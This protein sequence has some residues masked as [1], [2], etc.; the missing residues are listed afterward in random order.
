MKSKQALLILLKEALLEGT[1]FESGLCHLTRFL[2]VSE[3]EK[4]KLLAVLGDNPKGPGIDF[5][6]FPKG[7]IEPR[8]EYLDELI[9][10]YENR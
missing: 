4:A 8:I 9:K 1:W 10:K 5:F 6:Y 7:E 2:D 3:A